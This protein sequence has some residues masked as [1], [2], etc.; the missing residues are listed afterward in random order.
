M[1]EDTPFRN[2]AT[3]YRTDRSNPVH[4]ESLI[5]PVHISPSPIVM[6]QE[7]IE[8]Q[9]HGAPE[10]HPYAND[11]LQHYSP[12]LLCKS[13]V[14]TADSHGEGVRQLRQQIN[15]AQHLASFLNNSRSN[16]PQ[17][18][19]HTDDVESWKA[20]VESLE[21]EIKRLQQDND[22][23]RNEL[24]GLK[25]HLDE[26]YMAFGSLKDQQQRELRAQDAKFQQAIQELNEMKAVLSSDDKSIRARLHE[27]TMQLKREQTENRELSLQLLERSLEVEILERKLLEEEDANKVWT[28]KYLGSL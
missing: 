8:H 12:C 24:E 7:Q 15:T 11:S 13:P 22:A 10:E 1:Y 23:Y 21:N 26:E 2:K 27:I 25:D 18:E 9:H 14:P 6:T 20:K 19:D 3:P 17:K 5:R 28:Y 16:K 4:C